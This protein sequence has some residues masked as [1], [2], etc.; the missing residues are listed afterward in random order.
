MIRPHNTLLFLLALG[1]LSIGLMFLVPEQGIALGNATIKY[2]TWEKFTASDTTVKVDME[3]ILRASHMAELD[4][5]NRA[6]EAEKLEKEEQERIRREQER[7]QRMLAARKLQFQEG[8][9]RLMKF[10]AALDRLKEGGKLRILHFGDS[11]IEGDRITSY[12]RDKWQKQYG[13]YGPGMVDA[14]PLAPSMSVKQ[15]HSDDWKR[16]TQFGRKDTT[17]K[18]HQYGYRAVFSR[19]GF[20][21]DSTASDST[22]SWL[23]LK[24]SR[25]GY[26][27]SRV[28]SNMI[29]Y[30]GD[31]KDSIPYQ[32]LVNDTLFD[33]GIIAP[34][35]SIR[36]LK[37]YFASQP[38]K[39][40]LE[41]PAERPMSFYGISLESSSGIAMDNIAMRGA[42]GLVFSKLE[43]GSTRA[44][45]EAEPIGLV[46]LQYGGNTVPYIKD[47]N[48]A[49]S[50]SK[51]LQRQ[52]RLLK[53]WLPNASIVLIGPSD[54]SKKEGTQFV[55]YEAVPWVRNALKE[56]ALKEGI[57][58]WD[59]YGAMGGYNSMPSW[60][61]NDPPLAGADH[62]HFT[63]KGAKQVAEW[64]FMA[65][66]EEI[67]EGE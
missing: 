56:M 7:I 47:E 67:G 27:T 61:N 43:R 10:Q 30:V 51:R 2:P 3:A 17:V 32:L 6:E 34:N 22:L 65:F 28:F 19:N 38:E 36:K 15:S 16:F 58:F 31:N 60:V 42:S 37:W 52:I 66:E 25:L 44:M 1:L 41:F 57:G 39:M 18:H 62:I 11:Q 29:A 9:D 59:I 40:R 49:K 64:L 24:P 12:L 21:L 8:S 33:S 55:T 53:T 45:F 20:G 35:D 26:G 5:I 46:I 4:S 13:G 54:M 14:V 63:P 48:H 23:E 50:Y